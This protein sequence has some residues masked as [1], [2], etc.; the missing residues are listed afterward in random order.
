MIPRLRPKFGSTEYRAALERRHS[1][2]NFEHSFATLMGVREAIAFPYGRTALLMLFRALGLRGREIICPAYTCVVVAHAIVLSGNIPVFVDS[3]T[4]GF[5][6]DFDRAEAAIGEQTGALIATSIHGYPVDLDRLAAISARFPHVE[7]IQDCAHSFAAEW[8]KRPVHRAGRAAIFGLNISKIMSSIFGG[9]VTTDDDAL[10]S[11][12]RALASDL[13]PATAMR[14]A[15]RL[16]YIAAAS[17]ALT[18]A[19]FGVVDCIRRAGLI[20]RF[21]EYYAEDVIDMPLDYL[22][23]IGRVEA[24]VGVVQCS[25]YPAIIAHRRRLADIYEEALRPYPGLRR[26]PL[27]EGATYSHYVARVPAADALAARALAA[28]VELGRV[29]DYSIPDMKAYR[30]YSRPDADFPQARLLNESVVNL[31]LWVDDATARRVAAA[32]GELT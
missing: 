26:P 28:G 1:V 31:P 20:N 2:Q 24:S 17:L 3:E 32:V 5:N 19:A 15:Q 22:Q 23:Q 4:D 21:T 18:P 16:A 6:M 8:K 11:R 13:K 27:V 30:K 25:A 12:L 14:Q 9:M 29:I 7:I 10:S